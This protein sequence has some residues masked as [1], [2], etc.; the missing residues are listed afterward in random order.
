MKEMKTNGFNGSQTTS[1][2]HGYW[3]PQHLL[4]LRAMVTVKDSET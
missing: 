4:T 1:N 3:L 2:R